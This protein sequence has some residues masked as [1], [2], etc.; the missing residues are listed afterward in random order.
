[1][2]NPNTLRLGAGF[3]LCWGLISL[4]EI[5]SLPCG[6]EKAVSLLLLGLG[7]HGQLIRKPHY[8]EVGGVSLRDIRRDT[9]PC[10]QLDQCGRFVGSRGTRLPDNKTNGHST[11]RSQ[12]LKDTS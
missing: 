5:L 4:R 2:C 6:E 11:V 3:P 10:T 7:P 9:R 12:F 1:M 8:L